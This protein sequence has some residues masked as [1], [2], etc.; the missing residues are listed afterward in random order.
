MAA[1][2][3][4]GTSRDWSMDLD[5]Q[6]NQPPGI[7][8]N[9]AAVKVCQRG[10]VRVVLLLV[11]KYMRNRSAKVER[12]RQRQRQSRL[13]RGVARPTLT[14]L[15]FWVRCATTVLPNSVLFSWA[16]AARS[17]SETAS[18]GAQPD[19]MQATTPV[20]E[21]PLTATLCALKPRQLT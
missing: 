10:R 15:S 21:T 11:L 14:R 5:E 17:T 4:A 1:S 13:E 16:A 8:T 9:T 7:A 2:H 19:P 12:R 18:Q 3:A 20:Q 6:E